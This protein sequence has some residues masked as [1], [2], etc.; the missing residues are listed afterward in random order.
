MRIVRGTLLKGNTGA[1]IA[2]DLWP[3]A[4]FMVLAIGFAA[5]C[6]RETLE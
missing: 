2:P 3:M 5:W 1:D 4:M 6:Y